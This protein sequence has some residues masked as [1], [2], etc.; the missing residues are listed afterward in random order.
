MRA[1]AET[2]T[3]PMPKSGATARMLMLP[4]TVV[5]L[6][7]WVVLYVAW[8]ALGISWGPGAPVH[9]ES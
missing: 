2:Q 9:I 1:D 8:F 4:Y 5:V 3:K 6:L 7:C